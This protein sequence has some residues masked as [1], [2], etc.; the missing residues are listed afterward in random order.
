VADSLIQITIGVLEE[1]ASVTER[2]LRGTGAYFTREAIKPL[3][4]ELV[5]IASGV[6]DGK[7]I[8]RVDSVTRGTASQTVTVESDDTAADD[9]LTIII[10]GYGR[11]VFT[12]V[13]TDAEV[14]AAPRTGLW[15]LETATDTAQAQSLCDAI[16][17]HPLTGHHLLATENDSGVITITAKLPGT[18]AH[19]I[20]LVD[21]AVAAAALVLGGTTLAGGDDVLTQPT[22]AIVF[23]TPDITADDTISIGA[24]EYTWK[25]S[26]STDNEITLNTT[27]ATAATNFAAKI[28]ADT[29]WTGLLSASRDDAT[30]TL[31][32]LGD[33]RAGQHALITTVSETNAGAVAPGGTVLVTGTEVGSVGT[34]ITGSS[35][36]RTYGGRGAA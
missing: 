20:T 15:S 8:A 36:C 21:G 35:T 5:A 24:I 11:A 19:G 2:C 29:R 14:V 26:A 6:R 7:I 4:E 34:T 3:L 22:L 16:N 17:D 33:P 9:T 13:D 10:P 32:W 25:A 1:P 28:N 18:W 30:V 23:G 12:A 27:P 31:T